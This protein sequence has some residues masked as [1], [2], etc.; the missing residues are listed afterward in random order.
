MTNFEMNFEW[1]ER[2]KNEIKQILYIY[3]NSLEF[4]EGTLEEDRYQCTDL[5]SINNKIRIS[6]RVRR[7]KFYRN[8]YDE[9]TLTENP[10]KK[11]ELKKIMEG[12]G[13]YYFYGYCDKNESRI[14]AWAIYDLD[15]F[16]SWILDYMFLYSTFPGKIRD[17]NDSNGTEKF[18]II[19][20][21]NVPNIIV[22][23]SFKNENNPIRLF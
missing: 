13:N 17:K 2:F 7:F 3:F 23:K 4:T 1:S 11:P 8:N 18:R 22:A 10:D 21:T 9:L 15:I 5:I 14:H 6:A 12:W 20:V 16:R 19:D